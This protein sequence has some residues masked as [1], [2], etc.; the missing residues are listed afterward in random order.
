MTDGSDRCALEHMM[1]VE[2]QAPPF[3]KLRA[4]SGVGDLNENLLIQAYSTA[5]E[6]SPLIHGVGSGEVDV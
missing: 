6:S 4:G 2:P 5:A 1:D 3:A